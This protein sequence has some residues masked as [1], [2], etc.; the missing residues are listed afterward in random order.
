MT[1]PT[2]LRHEP[3]PQRFGFL[4]EPNAIFL[5]ALV[6]RIVLILTRSDFQHVP[7][8]L[9]KYGCIATSLASG[10]GFSS[11]FCDG[12]GPTAWGPPLYPFF[13]AAVFKLFG[14]HSMKSSVVIV[15]ANAPFGAAIASLIYGIG[16]RTFGLKTAR[17]SG[18]IWALLP[19]FTSFVL[20]TGWSTFTLWDTWF[21]AM[22]LALAFF[23]TL[24]VGKTG[25][26][27][28]WAG[29][30]VVWALTALTIPSLLSFLPFS[31]IWVAYRL[32]PE[33]EKL[34]RGL[35][36]FAVALVLLVGPWLLR[37]YL[38]FRSPV[39]IQDSF[40]VMLY[41]GN[42]PGAVGTHMDSRYPWFNRTE[43]Q[44][45]RRLGEP[46]YSAD[47]LRRA[48]GYIRNNFGNFTWIS[49]RR[50]FYFWSSAT[51]LA[52]PERRYLLKVALL[53]GSSLAA[54]W[55]L[56]LA[57]RRRVF[58]AFLFAALMVTYPLVFYITFSFPRFREVIEPE[59]L[60]LVV[61]A[62][63]ETFG[64]LSGKSGGNLRNEVIP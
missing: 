12:T 47:R 49:L 18:W 5:V 21:A 1:A 34:R 7:G 40:G 16:K 35:L 23:L 25:R 11:P 13:V 9:A 8:L 4:T 3:R 29:L 56:I 58:G 30:G 36:V 15:L 28:Y 54:W 31:L 33:R 14:I 55:G 22:F 48:L 44:D 6:I 62:I 53:F 41:V 57:L 32:R 45:F 64:I 39:F 43:N 59:L 10:H 60:L 38:V 46:H 24:K 27:K 51:S 37:N 17:W 26:L 50:V 42:S 63:T 61:F 20:H 19:L 52:D 2:E